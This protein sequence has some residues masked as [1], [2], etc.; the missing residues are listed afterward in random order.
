M[1][2][3]QCRLS[4]EKTFPLV[5]GPVRDPLSR[6]AGSLQPPG[7]TL[8][9]Q[10]CCR[11][12]LRLPAEQPQTEGVRKAKGPSRSGWCG[13]AAVLCGSQQGLPRRRTRTSTVAHGSARCQEEARLAH[14]SLRVPSGPGMPTV[15]LVTSTNPGCAV[16]SQFLQLTNAHSGTAVLVWKSTP[17]AEG[18]GDGVADSRQPRLLG[19]LLRPAGGWFSNPRR[20]QGWEQV[21]RASPGQAHTA[22]QKVP[23]VDYGR[24]CPPQMWE[25]SQAVAP[26]VRSV[27][28]S[29]QGTSSV[30]A[31]LLWGLGCPFPTGCGRCLR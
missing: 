2:L 16:A 24:W 18:D 4:V 14:S 1:G 21:P 22:P 31:W 25:V 20:S 29:G 28:K 11:P 17:A 12:R 3:Y 15:M 13:S 23:S 26:K 10:C 8:S 5:A 7:L 9:A 19:E 6:V 27:Q 30:R